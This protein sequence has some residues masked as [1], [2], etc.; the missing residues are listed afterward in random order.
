MANEVATQLQHPKHS[1]LYVCPVLH[2]IQQVPTSIP[3]QIAGSV[4]KSTIVVYDFF[5]FTTTEVQSSLSL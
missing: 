1:Q 3:T 2:P 5:F 4:R